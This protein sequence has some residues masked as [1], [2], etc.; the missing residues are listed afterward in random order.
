MTVQLAIFYAFALVTTLAALAVIT[1][2]NP[3]H[4][5]LC[6]VL[7]FF[8][9]A[10]LWLLL[11]AEFLAIALVLVYVGAVMVLFLFVVMML[12]VNLDPL[13]EGFARHLPVAVL[14]AVIMVAEM[15]AL[16][17]LRRFGQVIDS[18]DPAL[19]AGMHNVEWLGNALFRDYV[20]P[21]EVAAV[22]LTVAIIAAIA[23]TLRRRPG[24]KHQDPA[25]Q[26]QVRKADRLRM[27]KM[28]AVVKEP[29]P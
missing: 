20:L 16:I 25:L 4:A 26:V 19:A 9:T 18:P 14:V 28:D 2:R 24:A 7:T 29:K 5:V 27:V 10:C 22:V 11:E 6:L 8:S 23:L 1:V 17:G 15:L 13:R 3:V 21:F 12:D